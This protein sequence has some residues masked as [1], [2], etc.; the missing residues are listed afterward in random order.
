MR[1]ESL[2]GEGKGFWRWMEGRREEWREGR[3]EGRK[4]AGKEGRKGGGREGYEE[5]REGGGE[6]GRRDTERSLKQTAVEPPPP[7]PQPLQ[8]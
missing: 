1:T 3:K 5:G 7:F 2:F 8:L 4:E 6:E